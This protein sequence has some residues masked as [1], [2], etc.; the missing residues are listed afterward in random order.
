VL[1]VGDR[2]V[3]LVGAPNHVGGRLSSH[4]VAHALTV[5]LDFPRPAPTP[6]C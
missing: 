3:I 6:G 1:N 4:V 5:V 2:H